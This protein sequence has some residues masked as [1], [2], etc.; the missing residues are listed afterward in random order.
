MIRDIEIEELERRYFESIITFFRQDLKFIIN[1]L[2]SRI[3]TLNDWKEK[4]ES[5]KK[6]AYKTSDLDFGAERIFHHYLAP[7][8]RFPNSNPI[9][10]DLM[11]Q[12]DEAIIHIE[13]KTFLN[14]NK[15]DYKGKIQLAGNQLSYSGHGFTPNLPPIY[16]SLNLPTLTYAIQIIHEHMTPKINSFSVICIPNGNLKK[17]YGEEILQAGKAG[18]P[19]GKDIR[20]NFS[21]EPRFVLLT[22]EYKK[23]I[24][25][26]EVLF[27]DSEFAL[28]DIVGKRIN[29]KPFKIF[30][31]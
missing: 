22:E 11:Y 6:K 29:I 24:Y 16:K 12:T 5:T 2:N 9:G 14:T 25:R 13:V 23:N 28:E 30:K 4:F 10:S 8:F 3:H 17:Y 7:F 27:I 15:S 21:K 26:I 18:W 19:K 1:G 20:Y 31:Y